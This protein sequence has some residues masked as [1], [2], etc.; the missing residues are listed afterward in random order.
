[1]ARSELPSLSNSGEDVLIFKENKLNSRYTNL[2]TILIREFFCPLNY[3]IQ[4]IFLIGEENLPDCMMQM[5]LAAL[6]KILPM[7]SSSL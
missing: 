2:K 5:M 1:M 4:D 6:C 3:D 7:I